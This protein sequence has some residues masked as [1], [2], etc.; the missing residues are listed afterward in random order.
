[1]A[2]MPGLHIKKTMERR[3]A[4]AAV[5]RVSKNQ[6]ILLRANASTRKTATSRRAVDGERGS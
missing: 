6:P 2:A 5:L 4:S 1:M 3:S